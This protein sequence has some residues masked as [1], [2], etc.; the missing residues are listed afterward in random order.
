M[1]RGYLCCAVLI[2]LVF[3]L[4][5]CRADPAKATGDADVVFTLA[6]SMVEGRMVFVGVEGD[7]A[8]VV[9]P[10]LSVSAGHSVQLTVIN[11]DGIPHDLAIPDLNIK[12]A[13]LSGKGATAAVDFLAAAEQPQTYHYFCTVPGHRQAG[14]QGNL[15][16]R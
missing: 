6:T 4:A 3:G 11:G 15:V 9:N 2:L 5:G 10:S 1:K 8:G 13:L 16:V 7:I 14:M 12:T